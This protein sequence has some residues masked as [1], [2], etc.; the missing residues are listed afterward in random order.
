VSESAVAVH[1]SSDVQPPAAPLAPRRAGLAAA[2]AGGIALLTVVR[3]GIS[4]WDLASTAAVALL[5]WVAAI[6][7]E[8]RLIPNRLVV[9]ASV[10]L[11]L[12]ALLTD[13]GR[14]LEHLL[15]AVVG[16]LA[17]LVLVLLRPGGLGMGDMK[18]TVLIGAL[19]GAGVLGALIIGFVLSGLVAIGLVVRDGR[20]AL[21]RHL[22]L[23]PFLAAGAV[24]MLLLG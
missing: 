14:A 22:P 5:V 1:L 24:L 7:I 16:G 11:L 3:L 13:P 9:P 23:G 10:L 18:L 19:L 4:P 12:V 8:S 17:L 21:K 20:A 6:D 15:A 2:V